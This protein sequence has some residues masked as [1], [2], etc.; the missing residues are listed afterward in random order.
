MTTRLLPVSLLGL[1]LAGLARADV[2]S[3][4]KEG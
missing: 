2:V 3:G 4:P 1:L